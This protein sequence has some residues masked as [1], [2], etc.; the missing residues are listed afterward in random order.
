MYKAWIVALCAFILSIYGYSQG[1]IDKALSDIEKN[2][3]EL[4]SYAALIKSKE[5]ELKSG[6]NLPDP[7]VGVYYLPF[8][9]NTN[10]T[11]TEFEITQSFKFPTVYGQ[12]NKLIQKQKNQLK[13]EYAALRQEILLPAKQ[14]C[15]QLIYLNKRMV[16]EQ[17]RLKRSKKIFEH[18]KARYEQQEVGI[19]ELN[20]AKLVWLQDEFAFE[21][22]EVEQHNVQLQL[23][24]MN[25]GQPISITGSVYVD[26]L[27]LQ[28]LDSLWAEK[29]Q[30]DP[31]LTALLTQEE[32]A[33]QAIKLSKNNALPNLTAGFNSQGDGAGRYSGLYGGITIPL[34]NN[35]NKVRAAKEHYSYHQTL[36][37][38][39]TFE[40]YLEYQKQYKEYQFLFNKFE[41]YHEAIEGLKNEDLLYEAYQLGEISF[42][43]FYIESEFF[44][45]AHDELLQ[46]ENELNQLLSKLLQ[47]K[48]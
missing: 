35:R 44:H 21:R 47:H 4:K 42:T 34:W 2:N 27:K 36:T 25:G 17:L 31:Q 19:L 13:N 33:L 28:A 9:R 40:H 26:A 24:K 14:L 37:A 8:G 38:S 5:L 11:Y 6:N 43:E 48:L 39:H 32:V 30:M 45:K 16:V 12:N 3:T 7:T 15:L 29:K 22:F 20:K 10:G 1:E 46:M 41:D 18:M 23:E